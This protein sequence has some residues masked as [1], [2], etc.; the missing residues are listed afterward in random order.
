MN[1]MDKIRKKVY[2]A[3][4]YRAESD[5]TKNTATPERMYGKIWEP[6]Y[7]RFLERLEKVI[8]E[9]SF[10]TCLPHRDEGKWGEI[11]LPAREIA[12]ICFNH[13]DSS[14]I[15]VALPGHSR[16]VHLE[17]G[18]ATALN[19][20][21]IICLEDS[22]VESTLTPGLS[23]KTGTTFIRYRN[24]RDLISQLRKVFR[25]LYKGDERISIHAVIDLGSNT[26]KLDIG[27]VDINGTLEVIKH[28]ESSTKLMEGMLP[29]KILQPEP[30]N[31]NIETIKRWQKWNDEYNVNITRLVST[32]AVRK[33]LNRDFLISLIKKETGLDLE[34]ISEEQEAKILYKGAIHDFPDSKQSFAV[35]NIGGS[36]TEL[37][38]G[39]NTQVNKLYSLPLGT[40]ELRSKFLST[41]P[42]TER[43]Y[44]G[45]INCINTCLVRYEVQP[46]PI[47]TIFLHTGGELDYVI[48]A[49]CESKDFTLSQSH[50]KKILLPDFKNFLKRIRRLKSDQLY[51][52]APNPE[53][54]SW[55][56]GAI[57]CNAIAICMAG[58]L[59]VNEIVPSNIN[60]AHGLLLEIAN[61]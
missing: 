48:S 19:K 60:L 34:I 10:S 9:Y 59:G 1:N 12:K 16:G 29:T 35:M 20:I 41:N 11:Y 45:L 37:I 8:Q 30:I 40:R 38:I 61:I 52:L 58:K 23:Q 3:A 32:G 13:V 33:A 6:Q 43:E 39:T 54:P 51:M 15:I 49:G 17:L 36:T 53:N 31:R 18:Y 44:I 27:S 47:G 22:E 42:P 57:V 25:R 7:I 28:A 56:D 4:P 2:I 5:V 26:I 50:P 24:E 46:V 21:L 14:D 55:M